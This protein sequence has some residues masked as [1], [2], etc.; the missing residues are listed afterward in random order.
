MA[1]CI[2]EVNIVDA[3]RESEARRARL[4]ICA[5]AKLLG[6][7]S[8]NWRA[9]QDEKPEAKVTPVITIAFAM[10]R[11]KVVRAALVAVSRSLFGA[12][13]RI[14]RAVQ[15]SF[16]SSSSGLLALALSLVDGRGEGGE[17]AS[18]MRAPER[19]VSCL[20]TASKDKGTYSLLAL[21]MPRNLKADPSSIM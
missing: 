7:L 4:P 6:V 21:S 18:L 15:T 19:S 2:A 3:P 16:G 9:V 14:A 12:F 10:T 5:A 20:K 17:G 8:V 1:R 11:S 13:S